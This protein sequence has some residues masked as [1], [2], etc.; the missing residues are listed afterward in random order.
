MLSS[1]IKNNQEEIKFL[2][3]EGFTNLIKQMIQPTDM[4]TI[5]CGNSQIEDSIKSYFIFNCGVTKADEII[6]LSGSGFNDYEEQVCEYFEFDI[7]D[8]F[9]AYYVEDD[10]YKGLHINLFAIGEYIKIRIEN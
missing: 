5:E 6:T 3:N 8:V 10:Y 7:D 9:D 2:S 4:V 1:I